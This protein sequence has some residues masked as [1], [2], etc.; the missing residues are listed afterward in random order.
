MIDG[1]EYTQ[2]GFR[3]F[4]R[5]ALE[6]GSLRVQESSRAFDGPMAWLFRDGAECIEHCGQHVRPDPELSVGQAREL[7]AALEAFIHEAEAGE[8]METCEAR[9][10]ARRTKALALRALRCTHED[11][12]PLFPELVYARQTVGESPSADVD[13][14]A[15][16]PEP[17]TPDEQGSLT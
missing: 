14:M 1:K 13:A 7:V 16:R 4:G 17:P 3:V 15:G 12:E 6:R 5:V 10:V 2:R 11:W 8:L 9:E